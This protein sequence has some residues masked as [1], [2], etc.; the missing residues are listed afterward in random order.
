MPRRRE[1]A[2]LFDG[3]VASLLREK[4]LEAEGELLRLPGRGVVLRDEEAESKSQ[5]EQASSKAGLKV[6]LLKEVL[7]SLPVDKMRAQKMSPLLLRDR[8]LVKSF[9]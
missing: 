2:E 6:P 3:V 8:V 1:H 9:R 7:A 4:K 5:I